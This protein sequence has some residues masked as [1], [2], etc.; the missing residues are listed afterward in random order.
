MFA[1]TC[2]LPPI[3]LR[4]EQK[5]GLAPSC[6]CVGAR[7]SLGA[8]LPAMRPPIV[9]PV[10]K[11]G[12]K[13][14]CLLGKRT[15]VFVTSPSSPPSCL[16]TRR[17]CQ[18]CAHDQ[19]GEHAC[20]CNT[21]GGAGKSPDWAVAQVA[22]LFRSMGHCP[23]ANAPGFSLGQDDGHACSDQRYRLPCPGV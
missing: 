6:T 19:Y 21:H 3:Q 14:F 4:L 2:S 16:G 10:L 15:K 17:G 20:T 22:A 11:P 12:L 18:A 13:F 23:H 8:P 1:K 9:A 5:T 7:D